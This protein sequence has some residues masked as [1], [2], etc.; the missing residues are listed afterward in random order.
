MSTSRRAP[1]PGPVARRGIAA[2]TAV[3]LGGALAAVTLPTYASAATE[4]EVDYRIAN[5]WGSG[6]TADVEISNLGDPVD[7]WELSWDFDGDQRITNMWNATHTQSGATVTAAN[8][9]HNGSVGTGAS[10]SFGFQGTYGD[11]NPVPTAFTLNGTVCQGEVDPD[12]TDDPTDEPTDPD[13]TPGERVDNPYVGADV[14]VNPIWSANAAAEPGGDAVADEP[15]GVWLDRISAIEGNDSPTTGEMGLRDHLDEAL[16]QAGGQPLVF[17]LV[18]YN[19]PGRDCAALASNG[20][21]GPDEI[22]RYKD[23]YIDPI[24][25]ILADYEDTE[26][27]VV[28]TVEI[29][30]LPNLVTNVG[31]RPTATPEC[32]VMLANGNYV[33]GVGYALATLGA[34]DNVYNYVDAGHHGWIGWDDNFGASAQLFHEAA[35]AAGATP[36]DVH[37]FIANT[38]NYSALEEPYI[39]VDGV[40]GGALVRQSSWVDWNRY[41]DELSF[42]RALREELVGLGFDDGIGMLIDTSRNGWGGD[43][44]P[45]APSSSND[46]DTYVEQ[47]RMDRRIHVGN[48]CN[49]AGAGLGE[50]PQAAPASGIDAY[51]W[52]KPP[53]ESDGSS[54]EIPNDEGKGF[55]RMCDPTYEGNPRNGHSMSGALPNAPLSGHWFSEQF[56]ELLANAHPSVD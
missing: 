56:Q 19:L 32:D 17:Q 46:V 53:G 20:E 47:S 14:Y 7:G 50:R 6:F 27:R 16:A 25:D 10:V 38:A 39:D 36:D 43:G 51:V 8:V 3:L 4:C 30:S 48:W 49:Q 13:P 34:I 28:T 5:D 23:E 18:V 54:E 29:D 12:P 11:D 41:A 26:L 42:A 33:E 22:D 55:D 21:L 1:A 40:I 15:T 37:G 2:T 52:M 45:T 31:S 44:R 24:A 35:N 9:G